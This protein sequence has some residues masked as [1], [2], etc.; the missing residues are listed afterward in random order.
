VEKDRMA[1]AYLYLGSF[2]EGLCVTFFFI[3]GPPCKL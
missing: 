1:V 3:W 2:L